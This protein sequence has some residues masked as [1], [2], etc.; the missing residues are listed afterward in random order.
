MGWSGSRDLTP[1]RGVGVG[2]APG[3][4]SEVEFSARA[5]T[6]EVDLAK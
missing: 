1:D 6:E 5:E 2:E 3:G 4:R